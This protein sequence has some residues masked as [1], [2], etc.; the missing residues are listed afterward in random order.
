MVVRLEIFS[1][2]AMAPVIPDERFASWYLR[3]IPN[4]D[5]GPQS[6]N[7]NQHVLNQRFSTVGQ[8]EGHNQA[9]RSQ[10]GIGT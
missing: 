5:L 10:E 9:R 4:S 6:P 2:I 8:A 3:T 7:A 1:S